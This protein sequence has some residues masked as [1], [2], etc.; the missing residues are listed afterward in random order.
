MERLP[1]GE[2][3]RGWFSPAPPAFF[4]KIPFVIPKKQLSTDKF[5]MYFNQKGFLYLGWNDNLNLSFWVC[6]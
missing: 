6:F 2:K 4:I 5:Q 3:R 1:L